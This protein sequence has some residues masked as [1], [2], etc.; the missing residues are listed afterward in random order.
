MSEKSWKSYE[1]VAAY[2]LNQFAEHFDLGRFDG[3]QIVAGESGTSWEIDAKGY[4]EDNQHFVIV[5]C[6][7]HTKAGISQAITSSLAWSIQDTGA[8]GGILVSPLGLQAGAKK[9][10]AKADIHEVIMREDSTTTEYLI[11]FLDKVCL[12]L[13]DVISLSITETLTIIKRDIDG[14][15]IDEKRIV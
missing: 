3:K 4:S 12:G 10:A 5:E 7:R 9:V 11:K 2:L 15:I 14:N 13:T 1:E 8:S 6:K